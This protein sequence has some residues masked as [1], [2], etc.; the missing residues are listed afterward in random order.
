MFS[1]KERRTTQFLI[2]LI[3]VYPSHLKLFKQKYSSKYLPAFLAFF[4]I[5]QFFKTKSE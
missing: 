4:A 1:R 2:D 3:L 5:F